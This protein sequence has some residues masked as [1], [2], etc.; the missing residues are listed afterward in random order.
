[1]MRYAKFPLLDKDFL[2]HSQ[3]LNVL[4]P[5]SFYNSTLRNGT[6]VARQDLEHQGEITLWVQS[7][8]ASG[9]M[10]MRTVPM[11]LLLCTVLAAFVDVLVSYYITKTSRS[12][13]VVVHDYR[14]RVIFSPTYAAPRSVTCRSKTKK[15]KSKR[16]LQYRNV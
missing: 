5:M 16:R 1:M 14:T 9:M 4:L 10:L 13:H 12:C 11:I 7:V 2:N 15:T 3:M 6:C 8:V